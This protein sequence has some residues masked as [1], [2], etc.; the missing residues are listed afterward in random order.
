[1]HSNIHSNCLKP[2]YYRVF[3]F[4]TT[5]D[6]GEVADSSSARPTKKAFLQTW[7]FDKPASYISDNFCYLNACQIFEI[8]SGNLHSNR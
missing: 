7:R 5:T 2:F 3:S 8:R 6:K 1:M 4:D